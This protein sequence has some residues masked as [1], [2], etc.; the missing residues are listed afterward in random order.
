MSEA[1]SIACQYL[2]KLQLACPVK[3]EI[4]YDVTEE[5][6]IGYVF[7]YN[8]VEFWRTRDFAASLAGNGPILVLRKT[9]EIIILPSNQ[10]ARRSLGEL[11]Q[12]N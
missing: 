12:D 5:H 2:E 4:N 8:S 3:I 7:F 1:R 6:P 11:F 10:S 9:G